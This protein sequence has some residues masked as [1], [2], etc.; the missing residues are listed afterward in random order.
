MMGHI[1]TAYA[2]R[3]SKDLALCSR[4]DFNM[5]SYESEWTMG[6]EW[7]IRRGLRR[8][9]DPDAKEEHPLITNLST[10]PGD[11]Q[12]VVKAKISTSSVSSVGLIISLCLYLHI[13]LVERVIDVGGSNWTNSHQPWRVVRFLKQVKTHQCPRLRIGI[14]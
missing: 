13:P 14:L 2:A 9:M 4:F 3:V 12:G 1:S 7:W 5:Y 8:I 11:V 6:A 10:K